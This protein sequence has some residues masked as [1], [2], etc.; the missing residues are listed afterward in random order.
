MKRRPKK[1]PR[2]MRVIH[3]WT[4]PQAQKAVPYFRSVVGSLREQ[5]LNFRGAKR[6][7]ALQDQAPGQPT[8][9]ALIAKEHGLADQD[10]AETQF[11]EALQELLQL[12][13]YLLDPVRGLALI[14]FAKDEQLAWFVFDQFD[15]QG[16]STW[17]FHHDPLDL[18]RPLAEALAEPPLA[19]TAA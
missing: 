9:D 3:L 16:V 7:L 17:R 5:W 10:D 15:P 1:R 12:D 13:V 18:R 2:P 6:D 14:P 4:Y 8:R 11:T 19:P